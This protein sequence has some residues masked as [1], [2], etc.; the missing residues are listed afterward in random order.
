MLLETLARDP[1]D[2]T[3]WL[4]LADALEEQGD[5]RA[6]VVRLSLQLRR[7]LHDPEHSTWESRLRQR[8]ERGVRVP[9]PRQVIALPHGEDLSFVLVPPG[10]FLMG[11]PESEKFRQRGEQQHRVTLTRPFWMC[12]H[13]LTQSQWQAVTG[14]NPSH[15]QGPYLPVEQ[16]SWHDCRHFCRSLSERLG[17]PFRLPSEAEWEYACRAGTSTPFAFGETISTD[18]VNYDGGRTYGHGR[19]GVFRGRT[20][21]VEHFPANPWGLHDMHGNLSEWCGDRYAPYSAADVVDP[22][23][24]PAAADD[25]VVLRGGG[26]AFRPVYCRSAYRFSFLPAG[27]NE[28]CGCRIVLDQG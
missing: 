2:D 8:L 17:K 20:T 23:A 14:A 26:W 28:F 18:Q 1:G 3:A 15:F 13:L 10:S 27:R 5:S 9:L 25:N 12:T 24:A 19:L 4:A 16:V 21:P 11:S 6:E 7:D 22:K